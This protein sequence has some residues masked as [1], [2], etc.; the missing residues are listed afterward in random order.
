MQFNNTKK[1][2]QKTFLPRTIKQIISKECA[3]HFGSF[4]N[5]NKNYCCL[6]NKVCVFFTAEKLPRCGYFEEGVLPLNP[7][8]QLE[9][10]QQRKMKARNIPV[11]S[12]KNCLG[13][14]VRKSKNEKYCEGCKKIRKKDQDKLRMK[15][16]RSKSRKTHTFSSYKTMG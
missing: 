1:S 5:I 14:F 4:G 16:K 13:L 11:A 15:D 3:N 12:C 10:R 7:E 8:L 6:K 2:N 9:Y